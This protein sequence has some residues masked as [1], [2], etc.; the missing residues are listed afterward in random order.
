MQQGLTAIKFMNRRQ[1]ISALG[2][3]AAG[4][5]GG[6]SVGPG[7]GT[8]MDA[9]T[10]RQVASA[11][12]YPVAWC[13]SSGGPRGFVHVGV[14][15]A[16]HELGLK[17]DLV[18]G[19]SVG[20]L[21]GGLYAGG[22]YAGQLESMAMQVSLSSL[23]RLHLRGEGWISIAGLADLVNDDVHSQRLQ[24]FAIPFAA[25]AKAQASGALVAFNWGNAGLAVQAACSIE[26]RIAPVRIGGTAYVDADL[27]SPMPVRLAKSLGAIKV[28]AVDASAYEDQA[29]PGAESYRAS[30]LRKRALTQAD[31]AHAD[32]VLHPEFGYY[33]GASQEYRQRTIEAGY[34][35]TLQQAQALRALH[36]LS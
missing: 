17:P 4:L 21:V 30:D 2:W 6:C 9:D 3:S 32:L 28:L 31:A 11:R 8:A 1:T 35:Q 33:T 5:L 7:P 24:Q 29:P 23:F 22:V 19:S 15:K 14:L 27:V 20:A 18:M 25:V 34:R 10:P 26:G 13:F 12:R 16:L 36:G